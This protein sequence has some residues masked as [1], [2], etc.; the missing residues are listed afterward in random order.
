MP[1]VWQKRYTN[2]EDIAARLERRLQVGGS[3]STFGK[4]VLNEGLL[5]N[6]GAQI[7]ARIDSTLGRCYRLPLKLISQQTRG[8]L[9]SIAEKGILAEILP[10]EFVGD[11]GKEGGLRKIVADEYAAELAAICP[12]GLRLEGELLLADANTE[13]GNHT[14]LGK[15]K[16]IHHGHYHHIEG[17][18]PRHRFPYRV[19]ADSVRW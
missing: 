6:A 19:D 14:Q 13:A 5:N 3:Q 12:G 2:A 18:L 8:V 17:E 7:E 11:L 15:K 10:P 1:L 9:A 16:P 4:S